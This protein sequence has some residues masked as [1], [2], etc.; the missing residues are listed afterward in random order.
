VSYSPNLPDY[1]RQQI[2][3]RMAMRSTLPGQGGL[4]GISGVLGKHFGKDFV[5]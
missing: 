5:L 2:E 4:G 3:E 1:K